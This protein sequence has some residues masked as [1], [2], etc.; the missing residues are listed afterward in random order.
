MVEKEKEEG[1]SR[2]SDADD[3]SQSK[4]NEKMETN[5]EENTET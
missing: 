2:Q 3:G 5:S 1:S 4:E